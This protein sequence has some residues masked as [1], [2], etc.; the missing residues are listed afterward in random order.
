MRKDFIVSGSV[1][2]AAQRT[3]P[4]I[5]RNSISYGRLRF[6]FSLQNNNKF[7]LVTVHFFS[8]D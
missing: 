3:S 2:K 8:L 7:P 4:I 6:L 1:N 5:R